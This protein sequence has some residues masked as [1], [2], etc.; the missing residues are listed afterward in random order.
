MSYTF[1]VTI[2][3]QKRIE[4]CTE[5]P[6][7]VTNPTNLAEAERFYGRYVPPC[8][9]Y[10]NKLLLTMIIHLKEKMK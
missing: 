9:F 6:A 1:S 4:T 2:E 8:R 5:I 10:V 3:W 7:T